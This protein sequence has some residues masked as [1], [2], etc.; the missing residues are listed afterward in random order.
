VDIGDSL[1]LRDK[2]GLN[3]IVGFCRIKSQIGNLEGFRNSSMKNKTF[4][5]RRRRKFLN[6][7][8][9]KESESIKKPEYFIKFTQNWTRAGPGFFRCDPGFSDVFQMRPGP[10]FRS[11]NLENP[12]KPDFIKIPGFRAIGLGK[13][14]PGPGPNSN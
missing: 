4:Y 11:K 6:F 13:P 3:I 5:Q 9:F 7:W 12:E 8:M 1:C 14:G 2:C 10:G